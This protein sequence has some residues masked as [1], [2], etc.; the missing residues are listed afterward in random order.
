MDWLRFWTQFQAEIDKADVA[1]VT[2]FSYLKELVDPKVRSCIDGLPLSTEGYE[3]AKA[4]LETRYGDTSEIVNTYVQNIIYLPTIHG[5]N[6]GKINEFCN[7]LL[8]NVQS[9]ETLGK[10]KDVNSYVRMCLDKLEGIRGDL[11]RT[12]DDWCQWDFVKFVE[13]LR[14]WTEKNPVKIHDKPIE[15]SNKQAN[16]TRMNAFHARQRDIKQK[17]CAYCDDTNHAS[18]SFPKI[19]SSADR[20]KYLSEKRLCFNC[21]GVDHRASECR[22]R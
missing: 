10:L 8:Y 1:A 16:S 22:S 15:K 18:I 17:R 12:D 7:I 3:R 5:T 11:V 21:T 14:K 20:K 13:A 4:I 2:K 19:V 6:V 9:L